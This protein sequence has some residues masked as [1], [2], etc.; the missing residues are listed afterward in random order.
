VNAVFR[1][2]FWLDLEDGVAYLT[3]KASAETAKRWHEEVM[4]TWPALKNSPILA[5]RDAILNLQVSAVWFCDVFLATFFSTH[6]TRTS[7]RF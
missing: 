7:L 5:A 6:G 2:Q 1:P 4:A 3:A